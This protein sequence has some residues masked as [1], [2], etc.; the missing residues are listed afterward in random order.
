M[1]VE[2]RLIFLLFTAQQKLKTYLKNVML[3]ENVTEVRRTT[4][5]ESS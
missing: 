1:I 2:D 4:L 3:S 5:P